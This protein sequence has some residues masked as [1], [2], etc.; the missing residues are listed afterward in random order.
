MAYW[1]L[2]YH[3]V[4]ATY[5]RQALLE[6]SWETDLYTYLQ[7]KCKANQGFCYA[8]NGMP[9]HIHLIVQFPPTATLS[10]IAK[11]LKGSSSHWVKQ[12]F[13]PAFAWQ[14]GYGVFSVSESNLERAIQ[15]VLRQKIHHQQGKII[16]EFENLAFEDDDEA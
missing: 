14:K 11:N 6:A 9:D 10:V 3:F 2:F 13:N 8:V 1:R 15:Y 5:Q 12:S 7:D 4:W 16:S